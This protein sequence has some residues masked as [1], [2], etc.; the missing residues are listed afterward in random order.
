MLDT[1]WKQHTASWRGITTRLA[2]TDFE[3]AFEYIDKLILALMNMAG[4]FASSDLVGAEE[5]ALPVRLRAT[6]KNTDEAAEMPRRVCEGHVLGVQFGHRDT[7]LTRPF[8]MD[9]W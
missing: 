3:I 7:L 4:W 2:D 6:H 1:A 9:I 5:G 8:A